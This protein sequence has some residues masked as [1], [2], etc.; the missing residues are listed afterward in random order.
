MRDA[1][2]KRRRQNLAS[3][4][5]VPEHVRN[6]TVFCLLLHHELRDLLNEWDLYKDNYCSKAPLA[7]VTNI[8]PGW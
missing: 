8:G 2:S 7:K 4:T 3:S 5:L 1:L 6:A